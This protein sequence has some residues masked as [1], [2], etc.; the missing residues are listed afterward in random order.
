[1]AYCELIMKH[2]G[3]G[4]LDETRT[5]RQQVQN[6]YCLPEE[7]WVEW[8]KDELNLMSQ[9]EVLA[10]FETALQDYHYRKVYKLY[11]K[12]IIEKQI[13]GDAVF[14]RAVKIWGLHVEKGNDIWELYA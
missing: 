2:R 11:L 13:A 8:I 1:M 9:D 10:L 12:F 6:L 14:E 5:Y 4:D 7:M 3:R